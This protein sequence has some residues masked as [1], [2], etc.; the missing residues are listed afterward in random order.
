MAF[1]KSGAVVAYLDEPMLNALALAFLANEWLECFVASGLGNRG[2]VPAVLVLLLLA[3][4][5]WL[6]DLANPSLLNISLNIRSERVV[7]RCCWG[8]GAS[9]A[10]D[11]SILE[12]GGVRVRYKGKSEQA[13][14]VFL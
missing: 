13:M 8:V 12:W 2:V 9:I 7:S 3:P 1:G 14:L 4:L 5:D 11:G 6:L 10:D